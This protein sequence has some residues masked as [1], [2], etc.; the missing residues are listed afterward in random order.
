MP[1]DVKQAGNFVRDEVMSSF[2]RLVCH[3]SEL[4][5]Y[6]ARRLYNALKADVSQESM[7]LVAVWILG[8]FGDTILG[9]PQSVAEDD[10]HEVGT[11]IAVI[12]DHVR[13]WLSTSISNRLLL[14]KY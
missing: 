12:D 6:T 10:V 1:T 5:P 9:A 7:T 2:I 8:E 14:P 13:S 3:T 4:Q 11:S